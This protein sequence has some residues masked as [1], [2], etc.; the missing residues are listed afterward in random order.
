MMNFK[1]ILYLIAF[2]IWVYVMMDISDTLGFSKDALLSY[3]GSTALIL[4]IVY[5]FMLLIE[6]FI[7]IED[8]D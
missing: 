5:I 3:A 6:L 4:F 2:A 7:D 1:G 8:L